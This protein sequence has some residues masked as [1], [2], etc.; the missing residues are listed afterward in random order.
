MSDIGTITEIEPEDGLGWID[1]EDAS[2]V[3]FGVTACKG[4][5]PAIGM[6]VRVM[7]TRPGYGGTV[8]A[9]ELQRVA[10]AP[11]AAFAVAVPGAT[12][13]AAG[14]PP[15]TSL[16]DIQSS[17]VRADD[18]LLTLLGR[19][20]VDDGLHADLEAISFH[21]KTAPG[22]TLGCRNP[23]FYAV[24]TDGAGNA[25][26]LYAHPMFAGH[27][28][29]PWLF[30]EHASGALRW[31]ADDTATLFPR[32]LARA[33]GAGIGQD[34]L[35]R[36]GAD[37]V[38]HGMSEEAGHALDGGAKVAWLPPDEGELRPLAEYLAESDGGEMERGLL[39]HAYGRGDAQ[40]TEALR[41]IYTTWGWSL[42]AWAG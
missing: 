5:V 19:A 38:R 9:T 15:R 22:L 40:A 18:L 12:T 24:A 42:P 27:P 26:G 11:K 33:A 37:L 32:L 16:H 30:W 17:G 13:P 2:R 7:G 20:D 3:R 34:I 28:A 23:W 10:D 1:L 8:K 4:F 39:A 31:I 36:L 35:A 41:S 6:V 29:Q 14:Q 21:V 25:Y